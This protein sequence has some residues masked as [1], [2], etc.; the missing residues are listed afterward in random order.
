MATIWDERYAAEHYIFGTSPNEWLKDFLDHHTIESI[1]LPGEGEGRNAL[2]AARRGVAVTAFD[3][4]DTG[5]QKALALTQAEGLAIDYTVCNALQ[6]TSQRTFEA[7][8]LFYFHLP[9]DIRRNVMRHLS[10]FVQPDG[11]LVLECFAKSQLGRA[12]G[13]PSNADMLYSHTELI[14]DFAGWT[15]HTATECEVSLDEGPGH[16]G[17]AMVVRLLGQKGAFYLP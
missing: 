10:S 16:Q 12:S 7:L 1:L 11:W 15:W 14:D 3:L 6:Y 2:Y 17:K 9:S 5:R 8:G 13:G 4:S